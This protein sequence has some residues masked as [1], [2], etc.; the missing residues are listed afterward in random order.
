M[1]NEENNLINQKKE[2]TV[3]YFDFDKTIIDRDSIAP[4]L[5]FYL[6]K[7][8]K[9][10]I[11]LILLTPFFILFTLKITDNQKIKE[12]ISRLFKNM[13][14]KELESVSKYFANN[15][16]PKYYY[17]DALKQIEFHKEKGDT[18]VLI[19]ASYGL[20]IKFIAEN[21]GF[22]KYIATELWKFREHYTGY[23]YGKNCYKAEKR[24]RLLSEG[25]KE[26]E[27]KGR[28]AY[29]DS[30]SDLNLF[31]FAEYK[32]CVNPDKKLEAYAKENA[33]LGFSIVNWK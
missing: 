18:L 9:K 7:Y 26:T 6:K 16:I 30:I 17:K 3:A 20:Y 24:F 27:T 31:N 4:F 23:L 22:D 19:T 13:S 32:I 14:I 11:T 25:F 29:S 2:K 21:L 10:I 5:I 12:K 1:I 33:E 28:Y 15:I 8:P